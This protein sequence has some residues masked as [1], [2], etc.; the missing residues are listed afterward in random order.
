MPNWWSAW[1]NIIPLYQHCKRSGV[2]LN[3]GITVT[4]KICSPRKM[5]SS[6]KPTISVFQRCWMLFAAMWRTKR[7]ETGCQH[8]LRETG[9][10]IEACEKLVRTLCN[11]ANSVQYA[12]CSYYHCLLYR[13]SYSLA[14]ALQY[15]S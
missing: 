12:P 15:S 7:N 1:A 6:L 14:W 8:Y 9:K 5:P 2:T 13:I 11:T 4:A 3:D 10:S